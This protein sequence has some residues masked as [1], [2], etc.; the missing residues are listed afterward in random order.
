MM[1]CWWGSRGSGS[2]IGILTTF[3]HN[4]ETDGYRIRRATECTF[5]PDV[6]SDQTI[7]VN[8]SRGAE[9]Y[10]LVVFLSTLSCTA[11]SGPRAQ[12]PSRSVFATRAEKDN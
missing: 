4:C 5:S 11:A 12:Q 10:L 6:H 2:H 7:S 1:K 8:I 9:L 3:Y